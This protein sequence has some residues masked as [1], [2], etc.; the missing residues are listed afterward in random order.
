MSKPD[1]NPLPEMGEKILLSSL[2][3][4]LSPYALSV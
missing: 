2:S 4:A 1:A 3:P